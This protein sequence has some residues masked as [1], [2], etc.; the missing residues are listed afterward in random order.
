MGQWG[1]YILQGCTVYEILQAHSNP[2]SVDKF[3][4]WKHKHLHAKNSGI[5]YSWHLLQ[6]NSKNTSACKKPRALGKH[7]NGNSKCPYCAFEE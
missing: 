6:N 2:L 3:E 7:W 4:F 5:K 1:K